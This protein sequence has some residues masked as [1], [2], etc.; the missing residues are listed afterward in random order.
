MNIIKDTD[1]GTLGQSDCYQPKNII[2]YIDDSTAQDSMCLSS[3]TLSL[4]NSKENS[5]GNIYSDIIAKGYNTT[6]GITGVRHFIG[7]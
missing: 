7:E 5:I 1:Q 2:K 6:K 3:A 4:Y